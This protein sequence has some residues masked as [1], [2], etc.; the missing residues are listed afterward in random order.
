[1]GH[2]W[3]VGGVPL[4]RWTVRGATGAPS[5]SQAA[6][7][8]GRPAGVRGRS[9]Q[10]PFFVLQ[11]EQVVRDFGDAV[12]VLEED[13]Q[14][15]AAVQRASDLREE[16]PRRPEKASVVLMHH[17]VQLVE[18]D[19]GGADFGDGDAG[20]PVLLLVEQAF[21]SELLPEVDEMQ[22]GIL[23]ENGAPPM[24]LAEVQVDAA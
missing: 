11:L 2:G 24:T 15:V 23:H 8:R 17:R 16:V 22:F 4:F 12:Q 19:G 14:S 13:V 3:T 9:E 18:G 5:P 7:S 6:R 20:L 1:M 21:P 10:A